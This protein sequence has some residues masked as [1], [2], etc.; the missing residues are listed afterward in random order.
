[1]IAHAGHDAS[2]DVWALGVLIYEMFMVG[3][4]FA[5]ATHNNVKEI[6]TK[7][8]Q[9]QKNGLGLKDALDQRAGSTRA[10]ELVSALIQYDPPK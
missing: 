2:V 7:I 10:G 6:F 4:P 5:S 9:M 8:T 1:M 3:T